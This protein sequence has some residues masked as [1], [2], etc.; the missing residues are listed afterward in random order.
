M[1]KQKKCL[2]FCRYIGYL[3]MLLYRK[4]QDFYVLLNEDLF[5]MKILFQ[6]GFQ[7]KN[8]ISSKEKHKITIPWRKHGFFNKK[9]ASTPYR[10]SLYQVLR[11]SA[12]G[13]FCFYIRKQAGLRRPKDIHWDHIDTGL[14]CV[15]IWSSLVRGD[16]TQME[17]KCKVDH[18]QNTTMSTYCITTQRE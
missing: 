8:N 6:L 5:S 15:C 1:I 9:E 7:L 17:M 10:Q 16:G 4:Y 18:S 2:S 11:A 3:I 13:S 12:N 14:C